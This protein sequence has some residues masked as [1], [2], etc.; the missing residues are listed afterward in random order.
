MNMSEGNDEGTLRIHVRALARIT[1]L[2]R[3]I[4][5]GRCSSVGQLA[6]VVERK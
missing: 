3:E 4:D 5:S 2:D 1:L 6:E